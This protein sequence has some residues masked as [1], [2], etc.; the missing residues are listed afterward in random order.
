MLIVA[1]FGTRHSDVVT[2]TKTKIYSLF[3][4]HHHPDKKQQKQ[5]IIIFQ[6]GTHYH[7]D[8]R[9]CGLFSILLFCLPVFGF[10]HTLRY[11]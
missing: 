1:A 2:T 11:I 8:P 9:I 3:T 4:F 10:F 7:Y 6:N 5:G